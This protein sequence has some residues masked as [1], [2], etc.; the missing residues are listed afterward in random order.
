M[1]RVILSYNMVNEHI[2]TNMLPELVEAGI[3]VEALRCAPTGPR[4]GHALVRI[5]GPPEVLERELADIDQRVGKWCSVQ[6][7]KIAPGDYMAHVSNHDCA[8]CHLM[9][10]SGCFVESASA[11]PGG[12]VVWN[13]IS[14]DVDA[15]NRLVESLKDTGRIARVQSTHD[16]DSRKA[17]TY[18]QMRNLQL[19][20]E[21]GYYDIPQRTTLEQ[22][23]P[24][25]GCSKSTLNVILRRAERKLLADY[26][27]RS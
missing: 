1:R 19:A 11:K 24:M 18:H 13:L 27:G 6:L 10:D 17:L 4:S 26:L 22:L 20:F 21:Q 23:V 15:V 9:Q 5:Q 7:C 25:A 12:I 14:P 8:L 2:C 3:S 16:R